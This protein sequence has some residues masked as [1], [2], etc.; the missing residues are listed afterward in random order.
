MLFLQNSN[1]Y[2]KIT[3]ANLKYAL[4]TFE[5]QL[6]LKTQMHC[7]ISIVLLQKSLYCGFPDT[8]PLLIIEQL[9]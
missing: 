6:T 1:T 3:N 5:Q 9:Y 2:P 7:G 4:W 8:I